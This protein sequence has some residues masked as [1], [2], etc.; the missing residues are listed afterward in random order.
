MARNGVKSLAKYWFFQLHRLALRAGLIILPNH[1][2]IGIPDV[3]QLERNKKR[4]ARRSACAGL[5]LDPAEQ[6]RRIA[7]ICKPFEP[8]YRGNLA[9]L[10]G[11]ARH[12]GP[13][14]GY[15]EA[16]ALHGVIRSLQPNRIIEVGSG[17]ST[18]CML[19]A[20]SRNTQKPE[21]TCIEP[22]PSRWLKT[23][24]VNLIQREVQDVQPEL[25][26][27]LG[28]NDLL[29]IDSS[30][31]VKVDS[32]VN[33]LILEVLPQLRPGVLVHF[34]DIT[35][36]YDFARD[37]LTTFTHWSETVLL[38]A[39]LIGNRQFEVLFCLSQLHYDAPEVLKDAFPEYRPQEDDNGLLRSGG[40]PF[41]RGEGH[42]PASIYLQVVNAL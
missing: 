24:P 10:E 9:Y 29:F 5:R 13:G 17:V 7:G 28:K 21:I 12:C 34:H 31:S 33:F 6:A 2:S 38:H 40:R 41:E 19:N 22:Y 20:A 32:D 14:F 3:H 4:W 39:F 36:P 1:Y 11:A 42:F 30:H 27:T 18:Y 23:A 16:Q 37:T 26:R 25:F 15:I 8:E 35:L